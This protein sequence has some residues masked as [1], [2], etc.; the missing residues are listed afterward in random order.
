MA[1]FILLMRGDATQPE[2]AGL[3]DAYFTRLH[4]SG[5]F[6][7]GSSIGDGK[8]FRKGAA[9]STELTPLAGYIRLHVADLAEAETFLTGNPVY[10]SG[11]SV[12][13]RELPRD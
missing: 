9:A 4:A 2:D 12:E 6:D 7:G 1:D 13:I 8:R 3:W 5:A 11:G 10:E